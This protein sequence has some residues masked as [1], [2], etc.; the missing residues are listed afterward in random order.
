MTARPDSVR[1]FLAHAD[2]IDILIPT[3]YNADAQGFVW[4]GIDPVVLEHARKMR[5]PVMPIIVNPGFRQEIIHGLLGDAAARHR[6]MQALLEECR[7][8]KYYGFQFDF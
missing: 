2:K 1:A 5:V 7:R 3:G 6:M 4:G 8:H